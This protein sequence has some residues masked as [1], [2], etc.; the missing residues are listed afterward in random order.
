MKMLAPRRHAQRVDEVLAALQ[1]TATGLSDAEAAR[2]LARYGPNRL[3]PPPRTP[4][5]RILLN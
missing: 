2:R 1:T 4:A 3:P 5:L